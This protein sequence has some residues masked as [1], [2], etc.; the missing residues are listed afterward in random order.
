MD[1]VSTSIINLLVIVI[2]IVI[3]RERPNPVVAQRL[4]AIF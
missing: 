1:V 4:A 3:I 2:V